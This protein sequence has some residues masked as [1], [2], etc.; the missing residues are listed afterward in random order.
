MGRRFGRDRIGAR[1]Q[2]DH[3]EGTAGRELARGRRTGRQRPGVARRTGEVHVA[4]RSRG[5][6]GAVCGC[7]VCLEPD[8]RRGRDTVRAHR[9]EI[10]EVRRGAERLELP[11][12]AVHQT[13]HRHPIAA[14]G[15]G[16]RAQAEHPARLAIQAVEHGVDDGAAGHRPVPQVA[17][18]VGV[19]GDLGAGIERG[20]RPPPRAVGVG[21][22]SG[23]GRISKARVEG[24]LEGRFEGRRRLG[25]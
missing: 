1:G 3:G 22:V 17:L 19:P 25:P 21:Q 6:V 16:D 8:I 9:R 7:Q 5:Q 10:G 23:A 14:V 2:D 13:G 4:H 11:G 15:G 20:E 24:R 12:A 18:G